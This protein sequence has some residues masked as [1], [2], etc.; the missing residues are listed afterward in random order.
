M[1][2]ERIKMM[3]VEGTEGRGPIEAILVLVACT[4]YRAVLR[5]GSISRRYQK[6][7]RL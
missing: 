3:I 4:Q 6:R 2:K 1:A 7:Y 5:M